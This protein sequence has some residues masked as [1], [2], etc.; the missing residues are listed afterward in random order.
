MNILL[1]LLNLAIELA[2]LFLL[3]VALIALIIT[4]VNLGWWII[5]STVVVT[6]LSAL[7]GK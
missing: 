1:F 5:L 3:G 6:V 7:R 2:W 4:P